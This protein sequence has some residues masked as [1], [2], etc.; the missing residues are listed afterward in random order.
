MN[1]LII[2]IFLFH[3][4]A[5]L[6]QNVKGK[7]A[8]QTNSA[9]AGATVSW[10]GKPQTAVM[11]DENGMF[12]IARIP[13]EERLTFSFIG[14]KPDTLYASGDR[15][16]VLIMKENTTDLQEVVV[17]SAGTAL[18]KMSPIHT[19]I[20]SSKELLKA[21]CCNLSE[22]FETNASISVGNTDA[23]TGSRQIQLLGM[24]G[25]YVQTT[26]ENIPAIRGLGQTFGMN[27]IPGTWIQSID[28]G[29]GVGSVVTGAEN[30]VGQ[31]NVEL[32]KP[33]LPEKLLLNMYFNTFGRAEANLNIA[34][35]LKNQKWS[36]ALL[37]HGSL[38]KSE[39]DQNDDGFRDLPKYQQINLLNRWKYSGERLMAQVGGR[40]LSE[41]RAGGQTGFKSNT[42]TPG[43]YGF[44]NN[45][46]RYEL[47]S[48]TALLFPE[49]PYRGLGL[50]LNGTLHDSESWFGK[51]PYFGKQ[52]T[53]YG[54][55]IYQ[56]IFGNTNHTYKTG[57]SFLNDVFDEQYGSI[58]LD[59]NEVVP[60]L[61]FEYNY[62]NTDKTSILLGLRNDFHNL[63]GNFFLPR[64]HIMQKLAANHTLRLS[65]GR[66]Y[67][68]PNPFAEGYGMLVSSRSVRILEDLR[69]EVSWTFGGSY[70]IDFLPNLSLSGEFY[71]TRFENQMISDMEHDGY[72]YFYNLE[73]KSRTNSALLELTYGPVNGW[74]F[75]AG[76][77]YVNNKQTVGKPMGEKV[78]M[79]KMFLPQDRLLLNIGYSFPYDKWKLDGTLHVNGRQRI[80]VSHPIGDDMSYAEMTSQYAPTYINLNGQISRNY[81]KL[82]VYVGGENLTGFKMKNP[83]ISA[84]QPFGPEFDAGRIWGPVTGATVYTGFRYKIK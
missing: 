73:G 32:K 44:Q 41:D 51:T 28:I 77:R 63:Y 40:F 37:S 17:K 82:E 61:F 46:K 19:Q 30:M 48:K 7:V 36:Y 65:A 21:A 5:A 23:V 34:R 49:A 76:Y 70:V 81:P 31:V 45:T 10:A 71:H 66:G 59:R 56:D 53:L 6:S 20:I 47:F 2:A 13:A 3:S 9:I 55:L 25:S 72:L 58:F 64:V 4:A 52:N 57:L 68:V 69:P 75:K 26:T 79:D 12:S 24:S 54:N 42:S 35:K 74:E 62:K 39:I 67:R 27:Y 14:F 50:I 22:S 1:R 29:K 15:F 8:D 18:D 84:S 78:L 83:V 38:L 33:D 16:Y 43:L 80:P 60:G 11:T